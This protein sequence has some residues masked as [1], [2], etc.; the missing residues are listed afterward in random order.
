MIA[1]ERIIEQAMRM[2]AAQGIKSVR[3]DDIARQLGISKRTLYELF[4]D[5]EG[6]LYLAMSCYFEQD[7]LRHEAMT[8]DAGNVLEAMYIVLCDVM[9][10][11]GTTN[12][13][14]DNLRKF[15]PEVY[16]KLMSEGTEKNR[17]DFR[18]MLVQG[19]EEK[20]FTDRFDLDLAITVLYHTASGLVARKGGGFVLPAGIDQRQAFMQIISTFLR[21]ISTPKGLRL[22]DD[23]LKRYGPSCGR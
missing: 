2:F 14:L 12:R 13:M 22:V 15:Y 18:K 6:L 17:A 7:R 20:L 5:K 19:I 8:R 16:D 1:K 3:M 23:C 4:G 11:S 21:G 10:T 9:D